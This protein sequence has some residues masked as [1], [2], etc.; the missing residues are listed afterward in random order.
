MLLALTGA[1]AALP[2]ERAK[3]QESLESRPTVGCLH[4]APPPACASF[5]IVELQASEGWLVSDQPGRPY[6]PDLTRYEWN[7]GH[8]ANLGDHWALGGTVSV[9]SGSDG[10]FTSARGRLRRWVSPDVSLELEA[11]LAESNGN[12]AW[13]PAITGGSVGL[14]FNIRDWGSAFVRYDDFGAPPD[15]LFL[16]PDRP[17]VP[18]S[19]QNVVQVG[20]AL[21]GTAALAGTGV[22]VAAYAV[23]LGLF[24]AGGGG[25]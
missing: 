9:G 6:R 23:L 21:G 2:A 10:I 24:L 19:R 20:I 25:S 4:G 14:R 5:W 13:Y 22:V 12:G 1:C 7:L 16:G 15:S 3:G 17:R 18:W 8:L 11:G